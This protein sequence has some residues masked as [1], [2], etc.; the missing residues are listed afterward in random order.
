MHERAVARP[1]GHRAI[2]ESPLLL[3]LKKEILVLSHQLTEY[4]ILNDNKIL[5]VIDGGV[6]MVNV[7]GHFIAL[8]IELHFAAARNGHIE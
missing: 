4:I 5:I 7:V 2:R 8:F 1:P 6:I 3:R